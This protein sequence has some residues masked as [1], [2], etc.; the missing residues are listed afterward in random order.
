M[1]GPDPNRVMRVHL[2][3]DVADL[4]N[5]F[6]SQLL[7]SL[8][9][10]PAVHAVTTGTR[11]DA[12]EAAAADVVHLHWP[13]ALTRWREPNDG[14]IEA[15][16]RALRDLARTAAI[17][18]T[19]HNEYPHYRDTERYRRLY[20]VVYSRADGMIH[21]GNAS[22]DAVSRRFPDLV[23][24][25]AHAVIPHG[26]YSCLPNEISREEARRWLGLGPDDRVF[27]CFGRLRAEEELTLL[28]EAFRAARIPTKRLVIASRL[29][30]RG[31]TDWNR[32]RIRI[33][34]RL[35]PR[36]RL[37]ERFVDDADVQRFVNASDVVVI[38]RR[39]ALNS[40]NVALGFTF[41]RVV[42]GPDLGVIGEILAE[43][44]NPRYDP[45]IPGAFARAL[46]A[47]A[48]LAR[49]GH[50]ERNR[51]FAEATMR[52]NDLADRH[53]RFFSDLIAGRS[54]VIG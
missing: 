27:L 52:W 24:R 20:G 19:V 18:V 7:A 13:E 1:W 54:E 6:G 4:G 50:G 40:G 43:T 38:P 36:I 28:T 5:A 44:G 42:V 14:A 46:E 15:L 23:A 29:P 39:S 26:D 45:A 12:P 3:I 17:V 16:D 31:R 30:F 8:R 21:L 25:C 47:G 53:V 10:H 49:A 48:D 33:P 51:E 11:L 32:Y 35:A 34:L 2:G 22:R 41:G 37:D 9:S